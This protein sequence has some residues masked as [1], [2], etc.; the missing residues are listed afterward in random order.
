MATCYL[1]EAYER[2][3]DLENALVYY[4]KSTELNPQLSDG[5]IGI[6]IIKDLEGK[7]AQAYQS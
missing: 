2:I 6:G 4:R 1:G 3:N 5:Y 7:T